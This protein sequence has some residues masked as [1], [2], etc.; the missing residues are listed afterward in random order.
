MKNIK[1]VFYRKNILK[2]MKGNSKLIIIILV[3]LLRLFFYCSVKMSGQEKINL[4]L[5]IN[6]MQVKSFFETKIFK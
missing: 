5:H 1:K 6:K 3:I 2:V 4:T